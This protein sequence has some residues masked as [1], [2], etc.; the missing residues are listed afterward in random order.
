MDNPKQVPLSIYPS[1]TLLFTL[2]GE[3]EYLHHISK[4]FYKWR[5]SELGSDFSHLRS[6]E[7]VS[8]G[9]YM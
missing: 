4:C 8:P 2:C 9:L 7:K 1:I 6:L 3:L 5:T